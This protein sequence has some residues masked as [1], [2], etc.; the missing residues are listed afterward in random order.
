VRAE[1]ELLEAGRL[2]A[3]GQ[4][5]EATLVA[6]RGLGMV[7]RDEPRARTGLLL[8]LGRCRLWGGDLEGARQ[9]FTDAEELA[10]LYDVTIVQLIARGHLAEIDR[11][12]GRAAEARDRSREAIEFAEAA[13]LAENAETSVAHLTLGNVLLDLGHLDEAAL[14]IRRGTELAARVPYVA[15]ETE[16]T[17]ANWRLAEAGSR[18]PA[19]G[20]V[21]QLT[22]R[23]LSVLRLLPTS[24]TPREIA[25]ELYLSLNT[26]KT[27]TRSLYRKLGVQT[28]HE[29]IEQA[30]QKHLLSLHTQGSDVDSVPTPPR[31]LRE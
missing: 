31:G 18:R 14:A 28:R 16:A 12:A 11:R 29:A 20:L 30:R 27:H 5:A 8:V 2:V 26:V 7:A 25:A 4:V 23:E 10:A 1:I 3:V 17:A 9:A 22:G 21:E 6:E 24:L 15:R 19:T 13:G